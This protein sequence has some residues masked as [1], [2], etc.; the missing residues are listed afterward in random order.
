MADARYRRK[1][2]SFVRGR[3][4][5]ARDPPA[6]K[7]SACSGDCF[8]ISLSMLPSADAARQH[9]KSQTHRCCMFLPLLVPFDPLRLFWHFAA[10]R[11][12]SDLGSLDQFRSDNTT[13]QLDSQLF[14]VEDATNDPGNRGGGGQPSWRVE[15]EYS[16][17]SSIL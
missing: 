3:R 4:P 16:Y 6:R 8:E 15:Y 17:R 12:L 13:L 1:G 14:A 7:S 5:L 2:F 9:N 11:W 10:S